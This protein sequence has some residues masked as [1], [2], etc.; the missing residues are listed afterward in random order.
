MYISELKMINGFK[1][2]N[3]LV[4]APATYS[5]F[6]NLNLFSLLVWMNYTFEKR[7]DK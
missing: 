7:Y 3:F 4:I 2:Q 1:I 5:V 6:S